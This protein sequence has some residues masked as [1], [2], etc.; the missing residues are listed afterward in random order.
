[1]TVS[2]TNEK[3]RVQAIRDQQW[4]RQACLELA[5]RLMPNASPAEVLEA[6]KEFHD[7]VTAGT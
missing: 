5:A 1:M 2:V 3:L 7:F 6:G 4:A